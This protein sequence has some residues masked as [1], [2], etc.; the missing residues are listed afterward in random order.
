MI[1]NTTQIP[2]KQAIKQVLRSARI[3][4]ETSNRELYLHCRHWLQIHLS[5]R[6]TGQ[7][8]FIQ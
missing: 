1:S 5:K 3:A 6:N 4:K 8:L 7:Y 2:I